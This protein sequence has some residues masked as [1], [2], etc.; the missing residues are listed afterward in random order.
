MGSFGD[1]LPGIEVVDAARSRGE[2]FRVGA[3][4]VELLGVMSRC[5]EL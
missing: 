1:V 2:M 4:V 5:L 3:R